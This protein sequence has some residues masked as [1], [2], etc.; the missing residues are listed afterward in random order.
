[1]STIPVSTVPAAV[2]ALTSQIQTQV[3]T[4]PAA[5]TILVIA[6]QEGSDAPDDLI[7][8]ARNIQRRVTE[9]TFIGDLSAQSLEET[10]T[11]DVLCS[12]WSGDPDPVANMNRAWVLA[13]YVET[14]VRTDPSLGG[15]VLIARP[16]GTTD[17]YSR[18]SETPVGRLTE[19]T[20]AV[21]VDTLN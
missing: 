4:D 3:N 19:I 18:V 2:A 9:R 17:G 10:Y 5:S 7:I 15:I 13:G 1:M 16:A 12:S 6:G 21:F 8:V 11:I 14:A 20:V